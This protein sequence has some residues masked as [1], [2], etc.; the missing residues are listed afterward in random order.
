M[1]W[2]GGSGGAED[3]DRCWARGGEASGAPP[4]CDSLPSPAPAG[5][6]KGPQK[7]R[8]HLEHLLVMLQLGSSEWLA[9][10]SPGNGCRGW[11]VKG[12]GSAAVGPWGILVGRRQQG[13]GRVLHTANGH[14]IV[15]QTDWLP[16][17]S[18]PKHRFRTGMNL[19][20][21]SDSL[22]SGADCYRLEPNPCARPNHPKHSG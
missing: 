1:T 14:A 13:D 19:A 11:G 22:Y 15:C 18:T 12:M 3:P 5:I 20:R 7:G 10:V 9:A 17:P 6:K 2:S 21:S 16:Y 4:L 8:N